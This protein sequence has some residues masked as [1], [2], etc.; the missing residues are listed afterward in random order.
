MTRMTHSVNIKD[1]VYHYNF[2]LSY[3]YKYAKKLSYERLTSIRNAI[4]NDDLE[5]AD[6]FSYCHTRLLNTVV[7]E[8]LVDSVE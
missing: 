1:N 5:S 8:H 7:M 3:D 6:C 4:D 2:P